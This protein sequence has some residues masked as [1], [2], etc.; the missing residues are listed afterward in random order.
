[1]KPVAP[2]TSQRHRERMIAGLDSQRILGSTPALCTDHGFFGL[3]VPGTCLLNIGSSPH[4]ITKR[5]RS[6][7]IVGGYRLRSSSGGQRT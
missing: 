6:L 7:T 3:H 1:M 2:D 5:A 4:V